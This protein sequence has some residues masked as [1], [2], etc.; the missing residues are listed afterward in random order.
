[1]TCNFTFCFVFYCFHYYYY[2][3]EVAVFLF[4][5]DFLAND[6]AIKKIVE[7]FDQKTF[8][9]YGNIEYF[10]HKKKKLTG[11]KFI[12]GMFKKNSYYFGW[13]PPFTAFFI[14][15]T[16]FKDFGKFKKINV[17]DDFELMFRFQELHSLKSKYLNE[18]ITFMGTGGYSSN[19]KSIIIIWP[20]SD[21]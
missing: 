8:I 17:S 14:K 4:S 21:C 11:R 6:N 20:I 10:D 3:A 2:Y 18:T 7:C 19:F 12:H 16:C 5:D 9:V 15:L 1:M 13:H